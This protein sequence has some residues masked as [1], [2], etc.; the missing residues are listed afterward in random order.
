MLYAVAF[1]L[2]VTLVVAAGY[3][4]SNDVRRNSFDACDVIVSNCLKE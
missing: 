1:V 2:L 4:G 3:S